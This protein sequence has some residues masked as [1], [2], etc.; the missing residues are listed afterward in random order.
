MLRQSCGL[1]QDY[2]STHLLYF[3]AYETTFNDSYFDTFLTYTFKT[4]DK[5]T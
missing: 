1:L 5:Q 2:C 4:V 3:I